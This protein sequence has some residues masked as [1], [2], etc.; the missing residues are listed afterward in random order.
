MSESNI[1]LFD[2]WAGSYDDSMRLSNDFPFVGREQVLDRVVSLAEAGPATQV[3]DIGTGTG[4]VAA[5]FIRLGCAVWGLDFSGKMLAR[6]RMKVPEATFMQGD[7]RRDSPPELQRHFDRIVSTYVFHEFPLTEKIDLLRRLLHDPIADGVR[8]AVGDIAFA[9]VE[10]QEAA[11]WQ[12]PGLWDEHE[13]YW[14]ADETMAA[15]ASNG[16]RARYEQVSPCGGV[17]VVEKES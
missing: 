11:H 15:C 13:Y 10:A 4:E 7:L 1:G 2:R 12:W 9:S 6:A 14:A 16:L 3:L 5:R 8:A 17:F